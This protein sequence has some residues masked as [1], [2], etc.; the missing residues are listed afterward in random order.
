MKKCSKCKIEKPLTAFNKNKSKSDG[1]S[2]ECR[3]CVN[4]YNKIYKV[5]HKEEAAQYNKIY[6][7]ENKDEIA[8][9]RKEYNKTHK[10]EIAMR[11]HRWYLENKELTK[12]RT[13]VAKKENPLRYNNYANKRRAQKAGTFVEHFSEADII[14][15]YGN[16][17]FYCGSNFEH[18][19]HY[20]P[21]SKG[22]SHTLENI[23][24]SCKDC[25]LVKNNKTPD[26][27]M[28]FLRTKK[29]I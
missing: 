9:Q 5:A 21:L 3:E 12:G 24:P 1:Y 16:K 2:T 4:S 27:W 20:V 29:A 19:D 14:L 25:N 23:R 8:V 11:G 13:K 22:G 15:T 28:E 26:E 18:I 17:C 7:V 10:I 6:Q